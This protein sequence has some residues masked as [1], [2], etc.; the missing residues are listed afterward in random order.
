MAGVIFQVADGIA[1]AGWFCVLVAVITRVADGIATGS[2]QFQFW[3]VKQNLI[4][5][6]WQMVLAY[7]S[8]EGWIIAHYVQCFFYCSVEV[9]VLLP[10]YTKIIY[11]DIVTSGV[12]MVIYMGRCLLMFF[13]PLSKCSWGIPN[14][15]LITFHPV[16]L[17]SVNDSTHLLG[18]ILIFWSNIMCLQNTGHIFSHTPLGVWN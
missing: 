3:G 15:F 14:I 11:G 6:M 16:T 4:L 1:T 10:H 8:I 13:E 2:V 9:L 7:V 17:V 18:R 12:K 5:S